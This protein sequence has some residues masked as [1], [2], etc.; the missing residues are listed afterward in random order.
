MNAQK[1]IRL[2]KPK[3]IS[4][5]VERINKKN[6]SFLLYKDAR[7]DMD[8]LDETFGPMNWKREHSRDN[9]NCVVSIWDDVKSQ[10][11]PKED[12]GMP[13]FADADKGLASDSFKR[14]CV[15]VGIG[16]ELYTAPSIMIARTSLDIRENYKGK[17][18]CYSD[19]YVNKIAYDKDRTIVA[20]QIKNRDTDE[21]VFNRRLKNAVIDSVFDI[22]EDVMVAEKP[23]KDNGGST[24]EKGITEEQSEQIVALAKELAVPKPKFLK[25]FEVSA[26]KDLTYNQA[27]EGLEKLEALKAQRDAAEKTADETVTASAGDSGN[28]PM[29]KVNAFIEAQNNPKEDVKETKAVSEEKTVEVESKD[30]APTNVEEKEDALNEALSKIEGASADNES[31]K[32]TA[33][34][35][36]FEDAESTTSNEEYGDVLFECDDDASDNMKSY[37]GVA[38]KDLPVAIMKPFARANSAI[39]KKVPEDVAIAIK[40]YYESLNNK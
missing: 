22:D 4:I 16:R 36:P 18:T 34:D 30:P 23:T 9:A 20:L 29:D 38:V 19:L 1:E 10:W 32:V 26:M 8:I 31:K 25:Q 28:S 6:V 3:E 33:D 12:V 7:V 35:I 2:L 14:A 11:I 5:R 37:I 39:A 17:E 40:N 27:V 15:N 13:S 21:V 24:A